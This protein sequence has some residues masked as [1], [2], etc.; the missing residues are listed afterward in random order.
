MADEHAEHSEHPT[1]TRDRPPVVDDAE[2]HRLVVRVDGE[3]AELVYRRSGARLILVHTGVPDAIGG[4]GI[5]GDLV[6]AAVERARSED[7]T[8]VPLCPYA[9]QWLEQ[10]PDVAATV[11]VDWQ[12]R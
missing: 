9:R 11:S 3:E 1:D 4:R 10:H 7:L 12:A 6:R 5:G 2:H 8:V